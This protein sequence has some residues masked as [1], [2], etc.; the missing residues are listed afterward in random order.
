MRWDIV[1][2]ADWDIV[3]CLNIYFQ[4][5]LWRWC[6]RCEMRYSNLR[7]FPLPN[8]NRLCTWPQVQIFRQT[9]QW[10]NLSREKGR[11]ISTAGRQLLH[12]IRVSIRA[13]TPG[14]RIY[15]LSYSLPPYH[16]SSLPTVEH[17]SG[18]WRVLAE[19]GCSV[20]RRPLPLVAAVQW[21]IVSRANQ[22]T[23]HVTIFS[24]QPLSRISN[25]FPMQPA[26]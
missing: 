20:E 17:P 21:R 5:I 2:F 15:N 11:F 22:H 12:L 24:L 10:S 3:T 25:P 23:A 9:C 4:E 7:C 14:A 13:R 19:Q 26:P 16:P 18:G 8:V 6:Q 1:T